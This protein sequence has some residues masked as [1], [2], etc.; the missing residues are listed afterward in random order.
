MICFQQFICNNPLTIYRE[1]KKS[2][3]FIAWKDRSRLLVIFQVKT[4][5]RVYR[6]TSWHKCQEVVALLI[7]QH[8]SIY[9]PRIDKLLC[10]PHSYKYICTISWLVACWNGLIYEMIRERENIYEKN[11][12]HICVSPHTHAQHTT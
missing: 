11:I 12:K 9:I 3:I 4:G 1:I 2:N 5:R 8:R 6:A 10:A 7:L